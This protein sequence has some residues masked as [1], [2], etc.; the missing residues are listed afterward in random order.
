MHR[1]I[2]NC[3]TNKVIDHL[4]RNGLNNQKKNLLICTQRQNCGNR[5]KTGKNK[6]VG[7]YKEGN[8]WVARFTI[9][10]GRYDDELDAVKAYNKAMKKFIGKYGIFNKGVNL[11]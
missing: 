6:Y 7:V 3:P 5:S 10:V 8:R 1:T 11:F 4:D 9:T 2:M